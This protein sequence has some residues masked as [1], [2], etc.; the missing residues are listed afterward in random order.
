MCFAKTEKKEIVD[1]LI[2][3]IETLLSGIA[4][5]ILIPFGIF[6]TG[7][8]GTAYIY[9]HESTAFFAGISGVVFYYGMIVWK[10]FR[11]IMTARGGWN[12]PLSAAKRSA[13]SM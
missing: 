1:Y 10:R 6:M 5:L 3:F 8:L 7:L 12:K 9:P 4:V 11:K 2:F 13:N